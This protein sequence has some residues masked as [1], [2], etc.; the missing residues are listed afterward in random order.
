MRKKIWVQ[1]VDALKA[2]SPESRKPEAWSSKAQIII[3]EDSFSV[4]KSDHLPEWAVVET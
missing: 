2:C 3:Q 1:G 4:R